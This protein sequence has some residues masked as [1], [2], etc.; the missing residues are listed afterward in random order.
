[1]RLL[2]RATLRRDWEQLTGR[3]FQAFENIMLEGTVLQ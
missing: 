2:P 1:M 3:C